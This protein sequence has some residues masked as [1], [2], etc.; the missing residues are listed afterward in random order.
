TARALPAGP[1]GN[2]QPPTLSE[3]FPSTWVAHG[4]T[5]AI[6]F[7]LSNP[8]EETGFVATSFS[9]T[10]PSGLVLANPLGA[11]GTCISMDEGIVSGSGGRE[12]QMSGGGLA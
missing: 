10:L 8:N 6:N 3:S 9:D 4:G 7:T 11:S 2:A 1:T 5:I 12:F